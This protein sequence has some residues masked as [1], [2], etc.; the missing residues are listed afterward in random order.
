MPQLLTGRTLGAQGAPLDGTGFVYDSEGRLGELLAQRC[1]P[2]YSQPIT[3]EFVFG[4]V[5]ASETSGTYERG[6]GVFPPG[7]AGPPEHIHPTYDEHF[8]IIQGEFIFRIDGKARPARQ[9]D[10]LVVAKGTPHTFR[11]VGEGLGAV[12]VET[13]AA[14]RTGQVIATLFGMTHEGKTALGGQP[15]FLHGMA[16]LSEYADDTVFTAPPPTIAVPLAKLLAPLARVLGHQA[17]DAKYLT[18][19]F[20]RLHV[21]QPTAPMRQVTV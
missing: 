7:N 8:E 18:E 16:I 14:A 13:R 3:G 2:V 15:K 12:I 19:E 17:S 6:V 21:E 4:I 5:V 1:S 10:Q 20:W 11:C 9:G